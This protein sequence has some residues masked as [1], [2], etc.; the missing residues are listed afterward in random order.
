VPSEGH[1]KDTQNE[2]RVKIQMNKKLI[3]LIIPLLIMPLVSFGY[4]HFTDDVIKKYKVHVGSL[5]L[6]VTGF[7]VDRCVMP[8]ANG[9]GIIFDDEL[10][11]N[12][13]E[14]DL[15]TTMVEIAADPISGGFVL[16][17][18]MWLHNGGKL[19]FRLD[20]WYD[21]DGPYDVDPCFDI[22]PGRPM[23]ELDQ[24]PWGFEMELYRHT[25][26]ADGN[27]VR[28]GP[29]NPTQEL[30]I[31]CDFI[32]VI[33]RITFEQPEPDETFQEDWQC[34]WI[35]LWVYFYAQDETMETSSET[36]GTL[37]PHPIPAR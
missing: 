13:W 3:A 37:G 24:P 10:M 28:V 9:N 32:E 25:L 6:D 15:G 19:P 23:I 14:N 8:D 7:H 31:P 22:P 33:Q 26:D 34:H 1:E 17:T 16:E 21:W 18:T 5:Y 20:W 27:Y 36:W 11:I 12:I 29:V 4:S 2:R 30:Y 35:K